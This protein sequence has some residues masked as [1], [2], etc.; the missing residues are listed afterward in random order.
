MVD[1]SSSSNQTQRMSNNHRSST[2]LRLYQVNAIA[3]A[4]SAITGM[5]GSRIFLAYPWMEFS[6]SC[7]NNDSPAVASKV[8]ATTR[9]VAKIR[10]IAIELSGDGGAV[11]GQSGAFFKHA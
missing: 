11:Q 5:A 2:E 1:D 4:V 9:I 8:S 7:G 3:A 6:M 10:E